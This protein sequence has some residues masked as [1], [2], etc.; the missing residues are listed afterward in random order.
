MYALR[1]GLTKQSAC[2]AHFHSNKVF[3]GDHYKKSG[4]AQKNSHLTAN[5]SSSA[6]LRGGGRKTFTVLIFSSDYAILSSKQIGVSNLDNWRPMFVEKFVKHLS[7]FF[8][9][10]EIILRKQIISIIQTN[11][12]QTLLT[13]SAASHATTHCSTT[14]P[15]AHFPPSSRLIAEIAAMQGV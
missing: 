10:I 3:R 13:I 15:T 2:Y 7:A 1:G 11:S 9:F 4:Q 12:I 5:S 6:A 14:I 8:M